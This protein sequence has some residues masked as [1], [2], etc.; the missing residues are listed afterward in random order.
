MGEMKRDYE[1]QKNMLRYIGDMYRRSRREIDCCRFD[2][3]M[4]AGLAND[5]QLVYLIDRALEDC[6]NDTK[7]IIRNDFLKKSEPQWYRNYYNATT[8]YRRRRRAVEEFM[9]CLNI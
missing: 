2:S 3:V 7:L 4:P 6:S 5:R 8:Y 9:H 1:T